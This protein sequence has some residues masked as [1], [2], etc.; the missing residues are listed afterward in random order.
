MFY[1]MMKIMKN[2][3][4]FK[5]NFILIFNLTL[6]CVLVL[7]NQLNFAQDYLIQNIQKSTFR[8][9]WIQIRSGSTVEKIW[10]DSLEIPFTKGDIINLAAGSHIFQFRAE[11]PGNWFMH[12]LVD[13][14]NIDAGDTLD[15]FL[16]FPEY[17]MINSDPY[18]A[19][20]R[21]NGKLLGQTPLLISK[22]D[23]I[24]NKITLSKDSYK[25]TTLF[26]LKNLSKAPMITLHIDAD[27]QIK[28]NQL[29]KINLSR[30]SKHKKLAL[31]TFG[32]SLA[33][34]SAAY[35][36]KKRADKNYDRY[37]KAGNPEDINRFYDL[38]K[39]NDRFSAAT[40]IIF[41][42]NLLASTYFFFKYWLNKK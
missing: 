36:L 39:K 24:A 21:M 38:T 42:I 12:D 16:I 18:G 28:K 13:T 11:N 22:P 23:L 1:P 26:G 4:T 8:M 34:G 37:R 2:N 17:K 29:K 31:L 30:K 32:V 35:F 27:A 6:L 20:I 40:Y 15:Y 33:S 10:I 19:N 41:E 3:N 25:D 9:G 7:F 5:R 14:V